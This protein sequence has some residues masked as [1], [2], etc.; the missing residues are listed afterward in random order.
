MYPNMS[1]D[2]VSIAIEMLCYIF[3][4]GATVLSFL[5]ALR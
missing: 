4:A 2:M 5:F 3:T 1:P